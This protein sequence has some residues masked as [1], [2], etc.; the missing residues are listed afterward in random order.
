MLTVYV[1]ESGHS[2][3]SRIVAMGGIMGN[4]LHMERFADRWR[5][6]LGR[7]RATAFHMSELE[8]FLG[9][10][11]EWTVP[12]REALLA[13]VFA[14]WED[15]FILPFGAAVIVEQYRRLPLIA[16]EAFIDPWFMCFQMC[17]SE[18]ARAQIWHRDDPSPKE[19]LAFFHDRQLE[20]QGRAVKAFRYL[21]DFGTHGHRLGSLTSASM[22][23]VIQL[24][25][26]D[27]VAYEIR[28]LI[29]NAIYHPEIPTRWPMRKLQEMPFS[30]TYMD[31]TGRVPDLAKGRFTFFKRSTII[32]HGD[33]TKILDWPVNWP[34][35]TKETKGE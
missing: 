22:T 34:I 8:G 21:Q 19:K 28:K 23:D 29:E 16:Q 30:C 35:K 20:Y 13:D 12:Q 27:L 1:D 7:H 3:D 18:A 31:F 6:V 2:S 25:A 15:L 14:C 5:N 10:Y 32:V 9:Q 4:H 11:A 24:Q 33:E 26:A 17:V